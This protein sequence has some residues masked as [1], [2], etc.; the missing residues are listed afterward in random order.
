LDKIWQPNADW[1]A[2]YGDMVKIETGSKI[3]TWWTVVF[4][5]WI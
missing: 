2:K 4:P 1:Y 5:H 3:P